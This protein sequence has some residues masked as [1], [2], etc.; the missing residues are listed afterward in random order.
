MEKMSATLGEK[1]K[2]KTIPAEHRNHFFHFCDTPRL[3][4]RI[5]SIR[6]RRAFAPDP[7]APPKAAGYPFVG[8]PA[9]VLSFA[10]SN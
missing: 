7:L 4:L 8:Y 6:I 3:K 9:V 2:K 5:L 10:R 1:Q